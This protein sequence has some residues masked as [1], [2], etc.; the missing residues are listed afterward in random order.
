V[1]GLGHVIRQA[2]LIGLFACG[3]VGPATALDPQLDLSQ[4]IHKRWTTD[5]GAPSRIIVLA[6]GRDGYLWIG[7]GDGLYRFDGVV[8]EKIPNPNAGAAQPPITELLAAHDGTIWMGYAD[9]HLDVYRNGA[10]HDASTPLA[11]AYVMRL[12]QTP[13]GTIWAVL[14]GP[15]K[16]LIRYTGGK[17]STLDASWGFPERQAIDAHVFRDGSLWVTTPRDVLRLRPGSRHFERIADAAGSAAISQDPQGTIWVSDNNGSRP[18]FPTARA[19]A[20]PVSTPLAVRSFETLF[21]RDGSLWGTNS[22]GVFRARVSPASPSPSVAPQV[23]QFHAADGLTSNT[24]ND[25]L[26]DREGNVWIATTRGLDMFRNASIVTEPKLTKSTRYGIFLFGASDGTVYAGTGDGVYRTRPGG[27]PEPLLEHVSESR[28]FCEGPEGTIW[29]FLEDRFFELRGGTMTAHPIPPLGDA[30]IE[31][32][33]VD[34]RNRLWVNVQSGGLFR[35]DSGR[36]TRLLAPN[37]GGNVGHMTTDRDGHLVMLLGSNRLA[38]ADDEARTQ[39]VLFQAQGFVS[40]LYQSSSGLFVGG[41]PGLTRVG[42]KDVEILSPKQ[43]PWLRGL[44]QMVE[45]PDGQTWLSSRVGIVMVDTASLGRAFSGPGLPVASTILNFADG[46][47]D[48]IG[49]TEKGAAHGGDGRVWF[50]TTG[51]AV[52]I[53]PRRLRRNPPPPPP[54]AIRALVTDGVRYLD[55]KQLFLAA[56]ISKI[57]IEY[58]GLSL[59][60]PERVRFRYRLDGVD[61]S[62]VDADG[63]RRTAF[64]TNLSPGKYQFHVIAA[65]G[66]GSWSATGATVSFTIAPTFLQS[67]WFKLLV[68]LAL[69]VLGWLAY[70]W[71]LRQATARLQAVFDVR[72]AERE[73]IAREL[74]DTLLQGCQGLLLRFQSIAN[75]F[76]V[77]VEPRNAM[78]DALSRADAVLAEGRARVRELRSSSDTADLAQSLANAAVDIISGKAPVFHLTV[79]GAQPALNAMVGEE[80]QKI[81]EEALRNVVKHASAKRVDAVLAYGRQALRLSVRDDGIGMPHSQP[82]QSQIGHFGLVGMRE[83][84]EGIGG[85]LEI[86]SREGGGT[87][88][89]VSV[90][91]QVAYKGRRL[92]PHVLRA[93]GSTGEHA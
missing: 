11:I 44:A 67:I 47:P 20:R 88:V 70:A 90:P 68:G 29:I 80:T 25:V 36:W 53:D 87:E 17:W 73:R 19:P 91:S 83:R 13:D 10:I 23:E 1:D 2:L 45:T 14:G 18:I 46:L 42:G 66:N 28:A 52:W 54:V 50:G 9:G 22:A 56:G 60:I 31:S 15:K 4:L 12:A 76:P 51:G 33:A 58:S 6:Q 49:R 34:G 32:C 35:W 39:R 30:D 40:T 82:P 65:N 26:E 75:R 77:G 59:S 38:R 84:A 8:F 93:A 81:F 57:A 86:A 37:S 55:P 78:E 89:I 61:S 72:I 3:F 41:A 63:R 92:W 71:R 24:T 79:E 5:E 85:R 27:R 21:D 48:V 16:P 69:A 43:Y 7:S 64:Y 62:W 74:H